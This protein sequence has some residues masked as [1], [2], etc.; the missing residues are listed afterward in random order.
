M[1]VDMNPF[2]TDVARVTRPWDLAP[3]VSPKP[4]ANLL[5]ETSPGVGPPLNA[6]VINYGHHLWVVCYQLLAIRGYPHEW[7]Y[8]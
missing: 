7:A 1:P 4:F 2:P 8:K 5:V 6:T 3:V